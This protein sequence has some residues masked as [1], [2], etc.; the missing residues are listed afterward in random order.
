MDAAGSALADGAGGEAGAGAAGGA[1]GAE[2]AEVSLLLIEPDGGG[3]VGNGDAG[4]V[5]ADAAGA[6]P[7]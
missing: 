1:I 6:A 7:V 3:I 5:A 2:A 4:T